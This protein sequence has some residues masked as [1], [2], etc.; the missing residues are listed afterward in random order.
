[1]VVITGIMDQTP[2]EVQADGGDTALPGEPAAESAL[3]S[4]KG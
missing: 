1:M 4:E 3:I 2:G